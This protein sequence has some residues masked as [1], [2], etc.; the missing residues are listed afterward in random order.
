MVLKIY[1]YLI[2]FFRA[3]FYLNV[4]LI[5]LNT[6]S[7]TAGTMLIRHCLISGC[8]ISGG[9][10]NDQA[11]AILKSGGSLIDQEKSMVGKGG[12]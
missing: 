12:G 9:F 3:Y 5:Y 6:T 10:L 1:F 11:L 8:L 7:L 4:I 2:N